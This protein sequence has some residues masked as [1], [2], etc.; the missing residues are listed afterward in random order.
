MINIANDLK[1]YIESKLTLYS[2]IYLDSF[3]MAS[4]SIMIRT[5]PSNATEDGYFDGS[6]SGVAD[7]AIYA[8]SKNPETA[9]SALYEISGLI[10]NKKLSLTDLL[11][12][13]M[14]IVTLPSL[15]T[16]IDTGESVY[17]FSVRVD[18]YSGGTL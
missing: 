14:T 13:N 18:Y 12:V 3:A 17:N 1:Q 5:L 6:V 7:I 15:I 8:R 10:D 9:I 16:K 4:E 11:F 2:T